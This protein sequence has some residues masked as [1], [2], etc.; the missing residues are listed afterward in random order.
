[1]SEPP[2][3]LVGKGA[4]ALP[5]QNFW[6]GDYVCS[7]SDSDSSWA[8]S[9]AHAGAYPLPTHPT[10]AR[11]THSARPHNRDAHPAS[12]E[13]HMRARCANPG[14]SRRTVP[15]EESHAAPVASSSSRA[16]PSTGRSAR[17]G[18]QRRCGAID[19]TNY[20][21]AP[22]DA[23]APAAIGCAVAM[24]GAAGTAHCVSKAVTPCSVA[25]IASPQPGFVM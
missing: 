8:S 11:S 13:D 3:V 24:P 25:L 18:P 15:S 1:M 9:P 7:D 20:A 21:V 16:A 14:T 23:A 17:A 6:G 10:H 22:K 5:S 19:Q 12:Y 4:A 2:C